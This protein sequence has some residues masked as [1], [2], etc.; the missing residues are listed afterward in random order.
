VPPPEDAIET[1]VRAA[2]DDLV[3]LSHRIHAHPEL[4]FEEERSARWVADALADVGY[5]V[6][7]GVGGLPTALAATVGSGPL[8]VA[9]CAE[10]DALPG[11]GHACGHNLIAA[12]A[13]GAAVGLAGVADDLGLRVSV[14]G[15][16]AEEGGGGKIEMLD[17]GVFDG[18]HLALMA[19][20]GPADAMQIHPLAVAHAHVTY[21]GRTAHAAA[22]PERGINAADAFTV[23]EVGIGL[24]RQ[25]LPSHMRLHGMRVRSG[26]AP[27]IVP[28]L[29]TGR[30]YV[31]ADTLAELAGVEERVWDCFRAGALATGATLELE[32]ESQHYSEMVN[33]ADLV[34]AFTAHWE[35]LRRRR[36][37]TAGTAGTTGT[38]GPMAMSRASTDMG[39]VSLVIPS[40]HPYLGIDSGD[41]VNHQAE[42]A[43][44]CAT[45][46]AD[47]V[48]VDG[49]VALACTAATAAVDDT[50]RGRLLGRER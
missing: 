40:I 18:V 26:D 38:A 9:V 11:V 10:Y 23:A 4:G 3:G 37:G 34:A 50:L 43:A 47:A 6:T 17:A 30:W 45:P 16:P 41:A 20:P 49:A 32:M 8:H 29:A 33:D 19:H 27:N 36:S 46:T 35:R 21:R 42:F 22:Y 28:D 39:N 5:D 14:L 31:R 25:H 2:T 48:L 44:H 1:A 12:M 7:A 13:V 24:L 15:T